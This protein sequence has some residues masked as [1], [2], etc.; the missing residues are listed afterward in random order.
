MV[1]L[2]TRIAQLERVLGQSGPEQWRAIL[3]AALSHPQFD[4]HRARIVAALCSRHPWYA[5]ATPGDRSYEGDP[6]LYLLSWHNRD[7]GFPHSRPHVRVY[8]RRS[9]LPEP[10]PPEPARMAVDPFIKYE[11]IRAD[12]H[13][14]AS[15]R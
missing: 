13:K 2:R 7:T 6:A 8:V 5:F 9:W 14:K 3:A 12:L 10:E 4:E 1:A 11:Q 15:K